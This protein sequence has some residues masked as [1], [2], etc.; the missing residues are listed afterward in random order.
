M[1]DPFFRLS[2]GQ[3]WHFHCCVVV[4]LTLETLLY[5][6]HMYFNI[7]RRFAFFNTALIFASVS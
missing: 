5:F 6:T 4:S 7:I 3:I 2:C 1:K